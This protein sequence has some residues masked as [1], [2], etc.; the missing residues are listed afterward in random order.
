MSQTQL[1]SSSKPLRDAR[2]SH[3]RAI[4][5]DA[6][7]AT[8]TVVNGNAESAG[9]V[10]ELGAAPAATSTAEELDA[11]ADAAEDDAQQ[12]AETAKEE[13]Q[14]QAQEMAPSSS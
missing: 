14:K 4:M 13:G 8:A 3:I 12:A 7:P 6:Y 10:S 11:A 1:S 5:C 9:S 2:T